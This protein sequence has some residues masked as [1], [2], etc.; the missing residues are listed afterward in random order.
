MLGGLPEQQTSAVHRSQRNGMANGVVKAN[1]LVATEPR[2]NDTIS[3]EYIR[4]ELCRIL[5]SSIFIQSNRLSQFLRFT[6]DAGV[7]GPQ[8]RH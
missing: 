1:G 2:S 6:V 7:K 8:S 5:E 3:Q 4:D